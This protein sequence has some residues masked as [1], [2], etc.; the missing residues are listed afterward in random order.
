MSVCIYGDPSVHSARESNVFT[1]VYLYTGGLVW[2]HL[3]W[4][5]LQ[6]EWVLWPFGLMWPSGVPPQLTS[7]GSH[8]S[9]WYTS[10]W[11]AFLLNII[12][13]ILSALEIGMIFFKIIEFSF[14][15]MCSNAR[16]FFNGPE[17]IREH[18][19]VLQ[20]ITI[21]SFGICCL[22]WLPF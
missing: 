10:Y 22:F 14:C 2:S 13:V 19:A 1:P 17:G 5:C 16:N 6:G 21:V 11:N 4:V 3:Q 9:R 15:K 18:C 12:S 7:N 20:G 8:L